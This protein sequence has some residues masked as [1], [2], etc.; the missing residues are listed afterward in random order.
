MLGKTLLNFRWILI[1]LSMVFVIAFGFGMQNLS[2]TNTY[3]SQ[4]GEGNPQLLAY[5]QLTSN[6]DETD[7][8]LIA[9]SPK[10]GNIFTQDMLSLTAELTDL[11][12]KAPFSTRVDSLTNYVYTFSQ[13]DDLVSEALFEHVSTLSDDEIKRRSGIALQE[14]GLVNVLVSNTGAVGGVNITISLPRDNF[15]AEVETVTEYVRDAVDDMSK[16]YGSVDIRLSGKIIQDKAFF[17]ASGADSASLFP[18]L[19]IVIFVVVFLIF[20]S[21]IAGILV[22]ITVVATGVSTLGIFGWNHVLLTPEGMSAT[23]MIIPLAVADCVH[24]FFGF[25]RERSSGIATRDAM[26]KSIRAN[27]KPIA[28][29][30]LT[31]ALGFFSLTF[32]ESP[33]F[34]TMGLMVAVGVLIAWVLS[35]TF[36]SLMLTV[37]P[38][39][40]LSSNSKNYFSQI[41]FSLIEKRTTGLL[42]C[43]TLLVAATGYGLTK[44]ELN[45]NTAEYFSPSMPYRQNIEWIDKN[46]GGVNNIQYSIPAESGSTIASPD[47]LNNLEKLSNWLRLQEKVTSVLSLSDVMKKL[48]KVMHQNADSWYVVPEEKTVAAQYLTLYEMSLPYGMGIT[49]LVNFD[50]TASRLNINLNISSNREIVDFDKKI[51][52]WMQN[53]LPAHMVSNGTSPDIMYAYQLSNNIPGIVIGLLFSVILMTIIMMF[54][55]KSIKLGLFCLLPN[56]LPIVIVFGLWGYIDGQIGLAVAIVMGM[57][58]GIVVDDTVHLLSKYSEARCV[59]FLDPKESV[60]YAL[61]SVSSALL[62]TTLAIASGFLVLTFSA[63]T[64][65]TDLGILTVLIIVSALI[66]DLLFLPALLL[67]LDRHH[68]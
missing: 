32:A 45:Q 18:M 14:Q 11:A 42:I 38:V 8:I 26:I 60:K 40:V 22:L 16:K 35:F 68:A 39:R 64:P 66:F 30:S 5:R 17:T 12:W 46:L 23:I 49:N 58:L 29:T 63:F 37:L 33:S 4:F 43:L 24:I 31:T 7:N 41:I 1:T 34:Q 2:F 25:S 21:I 57:T 47:Y 9:I 50:K 44:N 67:K 15:Q 65:N 56:L 6:Y 61:R 20:R 27:F 3:E 62:A 51:Q 36:F 52:E 59:L 55:L 48:N 10:S 19:I 13:D 53:N 28:L 54:A